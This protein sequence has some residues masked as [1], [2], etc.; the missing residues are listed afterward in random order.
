MLNISVSGHK[1]TIDIQRTFNI[2]IR[3]SKRTLQIEM[4]TSIVI[5]VQKVVY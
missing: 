1:C 5:H 4:I 2:K 3:H